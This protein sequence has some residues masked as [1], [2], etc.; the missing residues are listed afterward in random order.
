VKSSRSG[1]S[2]LKRNDGQP[3]QFK[4]ERERKTSL[5]RKLTKLGEIKENKYSQNNLI[6][7]MNL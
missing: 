6:S 2:S 1:Y 4:K 7:A 3:N 5:K